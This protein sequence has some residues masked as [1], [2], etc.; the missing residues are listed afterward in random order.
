MW[1]IHFN[2]LSPRGLSVQRTVTRGALDE[3]VKGGGNT[4]E[5]EQLAI[6]TQWRDTIES[7]ASQK[8]DAGKFDSHGMVTIGPDDVIVLRTLSPDLK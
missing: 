4:T 2:M 5:G 1:G 7:L 8:Y 6:F 3:L